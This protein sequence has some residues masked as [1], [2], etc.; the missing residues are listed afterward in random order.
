MAFTETASATVLKSFI[1]QGSSALLGSCYMGLSS[2]IPSSDG[3]N[4][5]EPSGG[6][7]ARTL[8]GISTQSATQVMSTPENGTTSNEEIIYFPEATSS[9]GTLSYFGL[10]ASETGT[11]PLIYGAL[12]SSVTVGANYVPLFR[13]GNFSLTL[14]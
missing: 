10:F 11:E 4:F 6:G 3:S 12:T 13:V 1:G 14:S 2:T 9:W 5:T 8:V 7:Y